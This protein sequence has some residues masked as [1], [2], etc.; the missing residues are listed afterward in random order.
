[1]ESI[2]LD[3]SEQIPEAAEIEEKM[4]GYRQQIAQGL[5]N[6]MSFAQAEE[7]WRQ[8]IADT[9]AI[10]ARFSSGIFSAFKEEVEIRKKPSTGE[11][12]PST[13]EEE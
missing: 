10:Y 9:E 7:L 2:E 8:L 5:Q 6:G 11:E 12:E 3:F 13:G 1:M 4:L